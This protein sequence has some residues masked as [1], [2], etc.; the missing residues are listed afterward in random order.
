MLPAISSFAVGLLFA[1][2]LSIAEMTDPARV[3]GFL[4][5]F[6]RWDA[7]LVFVMCG[8]LAV[9]LPLFPLIQKRHKALLGGAIQMP[10][11]SKIDAPLLLGAAIFGV[12]WGLAGLC[13]GPALANLASTSPGIGLFVLAMIAGQW[14]AI[15]FN[16][17]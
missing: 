12:G 15:K 11:Q 2:G 14:L 10:V 9:T 17:R 4:D 6:G 5:I 1:A 3:I 13:P 16:S 8:A 7:T